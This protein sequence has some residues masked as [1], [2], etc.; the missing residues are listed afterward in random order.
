ML[1]IRGKYNTAKVYTDNIEQ[2]A[3]GQVMA[4]CNLEAYKDS[5]IRI[6]PD[7]HVA[8]G[9]TVGTTMTL[10]NT[11][12]PNMVGVD[13][14]CGVLAIK[15]KEKRIDFPAFDSIIRKHVH[16]KDTTDWFN[17]DSLKCKTRGAGIRE[18]EANFSL[19]TLGGGNHF[20]ELAQDQETMDIWLVIHTGSRH[21][22]AEVCNFYQN[23]AYK[24]LKF[25]ANGGNK[26]T[27]TKEIIDRLKS[28]GKQ[29]EIEKE[30]KKFQ[31][32]YFEIEPDIP[33]ALC[34]CTGSLFDDY[35]HDMKVVQEYASQNRAI[36]AKT[37]LK[38]AKLHE[39]ERF[40]TV[41]NYIDT[42]NLI[43]RKGAVSAQAGEKLII[44]I[45]MRD[46]SLICIGKGNA[47]WNYSAP[48]GAGRLMSRA[49]AKEGLSVSEFKKTMKQ[50]GVYTTCVGQE[51]LD[52]SPMAYKPIDEIKAN[53]DETAEIKAWLK[54]IYN[55]KAS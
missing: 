43:L 28:E 15:L 38:K 55:F 1:E 12:I 40:E 49:D 13:I 6:M 42:D 5:Q 26:A 31:D 51:T 2:S 23:E 17:S 8:K 37:I 46:G 21:L 18:Q 53:I 36:I 11:A 4:M 45:N 3:V 27:K 25:I 19:G 35:I 29:N 34:H 32:S 22:G 24:E 47:D 54:T 52:E 7:V 16:G 10:T 41:H 14:G 30:I 33:Y 50:A 20:I 44:P 39:V 48:H 9:C